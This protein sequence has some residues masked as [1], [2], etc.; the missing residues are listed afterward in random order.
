MYNTI[1]TIRLGCKISFFMLTIKSNKNIILPESD[2]SENKL[3][4]ETKGEKESFSAAIK[5]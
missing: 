1:F 5:T 2:L 4:R 3:F